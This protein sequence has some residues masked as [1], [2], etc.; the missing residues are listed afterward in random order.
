MMEIINE[1]GSARQGL[2]RTGHGDIETPVF[3]PVG[4]QGIVKASTHRDLKEVGA[5]IILAN[6]YHLYLRPG[7]QLIREMGG[8]HRFS[9]WD[10]AVLTDSGGYQIFSLG[11][12]REIKD[13]GVLFQSHIDGSRHFLTPEKMVQVQ[14]NIG[15]D[16]CVCLDEC[17]S[18]PS[19]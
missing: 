7:D 19:S 5:K 9:G 15:A 10:G 17:V 13:D 6:A 1:E 11:V 8:I 12:L 2:L 16:I 3:M 18:Y 4:T 14:E